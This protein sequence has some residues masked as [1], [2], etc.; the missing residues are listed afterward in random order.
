MTW[1]RISVVPLTIWKKT[2]RAGTHGT[3]SEGARRAFTETTG[4]LQESA[5]RILQAMEYL[6]KWRHFGSVTN[7][8]RPDDVM[9]KI[10]IGFNILPT[11]ASLLKMLSMLP[12]PLPTSVQLFPRTQQKWRT[13]RTKSD[14]T[15]AS[16]LEKKSRLVWSALLRKLRPNYQCCPRIYR[17]QTTR[18]RAVTL[19][20]AITG[21]NAIGEVV[22]QSVETVQTLGQT[23]NKLGLLSASL[24]DC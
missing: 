23:V 1:F 16:Y 5:N 22:G 7:K 12:M 21:M 15:G 14:D 17:S 18:S 2:S 11:S 19:Y 9:N 3:Q 24:R 4:Y 20:E 8:Q 13:A 10:S 6:A